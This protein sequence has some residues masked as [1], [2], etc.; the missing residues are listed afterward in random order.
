MSMNNLSSF[1]TV[2]ALIAGSS[3][4]SAQVTRLLPEVTRSVIYN[5][6]P[7]D[8]TLTDSIHASLDALEFEAPE[9]NEMFFDGVEMVQ[10][11]DS[12]HFPGPEDIEYVDF[13]PYPL[14]TV[15]L[16]PTVF[17]RLHILP[18]YEIDPHIQLVPGV[19][20]YATEWASRSIAQTQLMERT[21][22]RYIVNYPHLIQYDEA[23]LPEPPKK[24]TATVDPATARIL[25]TEVIAKEMPVANLEAK[26]EKKHWLKTFNA[27]LQFSQAYVSPNWYQGG[28]NNLNI[29]AHAI[30]NVKL[31]QN[32]HPKLLFDTTIQYKLGMN[33]APD[34]S[35]RNY[36][37]SEDLFQINSTF[38]VK[39]AKRWFYSLTFQ[40]KTQVLNSYTSNTRT[41]RAAFLSPA[42]L[43]VG[44]GMTYNYS[45]KNFTFDASISPLAYNMKICT[46]RSMDVTA[47]GIKPGHKT[48]S[49]YGSTA[50]LKMRWAIAY[51]IIWQSRVFFFTD[52]S[53]I[54]ADWEN[55]L[56]FEINRFLTT[57]IYCHA[58]YDSSTPRTEGDHTWRKFMLKEIL[59]FGFAYKFSTI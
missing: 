5:Y 16:R 29:I 7:V 15:Y 25:I 58:R 27:N 17:D 42:D 6:T 30:W 24:F 34:D 4:V 2:A 46:D 50:E 1:L 40:F 12:I 49:Q 23:H 51:N 35:L 31:N 55:T 54:Q 43:N 52:Y 37:I 39:A 14:P 59:S 56:S 36:S 21:R 45:K 11:P 28:N 41:L 32:Y 9:M 8:S 10:Q 19:D 22:Q 20:H 38:G 33:S 18:P 57:Q 47:Y 13:N 3:S 26:F 44:V 48:V 53:Y